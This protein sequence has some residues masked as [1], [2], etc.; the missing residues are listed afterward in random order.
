MSYSKFA[1]DNVGATVEYEFS[2]RSGPWTTSSGVIIVDSDGSTCIKVSDE[3]SS[4][5]ILFPSP[6]TQYQNVRIL[7]ASA[8]NRTYTT[9]ANRAQSPEVLAPVHR[10]VLATQGTHER[11]VLRGNQELIL[12]KAAEGEHQRIQLLQS[13]KNWPRRPKESAKL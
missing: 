3:G 10:Q 5:E 8:N 12:N 7:S 4:K 1:S 2:F 6:E 13:N 9:S 11:E